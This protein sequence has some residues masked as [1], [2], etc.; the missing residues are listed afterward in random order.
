MGFFNQNSGFWKRV[1]LRISLK[2]AICDM[3]EYHT[4][5]QAGPFLTAPWDFVLWGCPGVN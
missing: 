5:E 2:M 4:Y 3:P 1:I